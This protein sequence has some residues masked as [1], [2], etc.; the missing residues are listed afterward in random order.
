MIDHMKKHSNPETIHPPVGAYT[1]QIEIANERR[2]LVIAGQIGMT[3]EGTVPDSV[4]EQLELA[5][6][7]VRLNLEAAGMS[8][9][10]LVKLTIFLTE[11]LASAERRTIIE[12]AVGSKP[13]TATLVYVARLAAPMLKAEVEALASAP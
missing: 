4:S 3:P 11:D 6:A 5:L 10:D 13:P 9:A 8:V 1:H 2:L 7:N 12:A